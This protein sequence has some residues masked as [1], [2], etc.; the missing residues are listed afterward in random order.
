MQSCVTLLQP[1]PLMM[2]LMTWTLT[3][4]MENALLPVPIAKTSS[5]GHLI[6]LNP[7][8]GRNRETRNSSVRTKQGTM[9][10]SKLSLQTSESVISPTNS[11]TSP[12]RVLPFESRL[13]TFLESISRSPSNI[14][15][16]RKSVYTLQNRQQAEMRKQANERRFAYTK[17]I[18]TPCNQAATSLIRVGKLPPMAPKTG[19]GGKPKVDAAIFRPTVQTL[20]ELTQSAN[21]NIQTIDAALTRAYDY[22]L[23]VLIQKKPLILR[24]AIMFLKL[25]YLDETIKIPG[26]TILDKLKGTTMEKEFGACLVRKGVLADKNPNCLLKLWIPARVQ[27]IFSKSI[28]TLGFGMTTLSAV[29]HVQIHANMVENLTHDFDFDAIYPSIPIS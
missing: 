15:N 4:C 21:S 27:S 8:S 5:G 28:I 22:A 10:V 12:F 25:D 16:C 7:D 20:S 19:T 2:L 11:E 14:E 23:Q 13:G 6:Q 26:L 3:N 9:D 24:S 1:I 29:E 18:N 17:T